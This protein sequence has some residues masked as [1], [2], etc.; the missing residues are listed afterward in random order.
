[1]KYQPMLSQ[2]AQKRNFNQSQAHSRAMRNKFIKYK[3]KSIKYK[4]NR[5]MA[6]IKSYQRR[7]YK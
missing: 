4:Q 3:S 2:E 7:K 1:M 5:K 6:L